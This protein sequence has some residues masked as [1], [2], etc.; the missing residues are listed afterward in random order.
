MRNLGIYPAIFNYKQVVRRSIS[1]A[2]FFTV[3]LRTVRVRERVTVLNLQVEIAYL[4]T[5]ADLKK[6]LKLVGLLFIY[7]F[8]LFIKL[9]C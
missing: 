3:P 8:T 9:V 1:V 6:T 4:T 2:G 5:L 7:A